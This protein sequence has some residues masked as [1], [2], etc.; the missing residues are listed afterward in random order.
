MAQRLVEPLALR[1]AASDRVA[2]SGAEVGRILAGRVAVMSEL[3]TGAGVQMPTDSEVSSRRAHEPPMSNTIS[4]MAEINI[5]SFV[6]T[7]SM[8]PSS[9]QS[10]A[11]DT[12]YAN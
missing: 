12:H 1:W 4:K 10:I 7:R 8:D 11:R 5:V 2:V 3:L 6:F 9:G